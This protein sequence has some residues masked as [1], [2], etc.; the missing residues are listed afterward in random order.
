MFFHPHRRPDTRC[1]RRSRQA[2]A[3]TTPQVKWMRHAVDSVLQVKVLVKTVALA[4][5]VYCAT[6]RSGYSFDVGVFTCSWRAR[7]SNNYIQEGHSVNKVVQ[8]IVLR[9]FSDVLLKIWHGS[10]TSAELWPRTIPGSRGRPLR[11]KVNSSGR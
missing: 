2:G 3:S 5:F 7:K 11:Q 6:C 8:S 1:G 10:A 4:H 9:R